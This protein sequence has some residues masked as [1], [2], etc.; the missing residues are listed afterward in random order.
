MAGIGGELP[1]GGR[2]FIEEGVVGDG[3]VGWMGEE[4]PS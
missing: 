4:V 3:V 1:L 2:V